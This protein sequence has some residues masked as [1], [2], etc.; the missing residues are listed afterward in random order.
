MNK[1]KI[2]FQTKNTNHIGKKWSHP[3]TL[4][5]NDSFTECYD[6][7]RY[8]VSVDEQNPSNSGIDI[9]Y[10]IWVQGEERWEAIYERKVTYEE[11]T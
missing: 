4:E 3:R 10:R 11:R 6:K 2:T 1:F 7:I 9:K 5:F 8:Y